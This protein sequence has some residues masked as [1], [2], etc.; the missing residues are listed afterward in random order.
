MFFIVFIGEICCNC[1]FFL[2]HLVCLTRKECVLPVT[3]KYGE[4]LN[5]LTVR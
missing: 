3:E 1:V 4:L 2:G 5:R